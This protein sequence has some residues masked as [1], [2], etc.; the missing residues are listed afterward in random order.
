MKV[1]LLT[2]PMPASP[3]G[4]ALL[5]AL[6][7]VTAVEYTPQ[8][9]D[10][11]LAEVD[12]VLAWSFP[13]GVAGRLK[14]LRWVCAVSAGVDKLLVPELHPDVPVSRIVDPEQGQ[15]IAQ[16]VALMALRHARQ[17]PL[18]ERQARDHQWRRHPVAAVR[19]T[20]LVLGTGAMGSAVAD[21]LR[22]VGFDVRGWSRQQGGALDDALAAADIVVCALPLTPQTHGLLDARRLACMRK[23][24]YLINIA[25]GHHV[26]EADLVDAVRSG[27]LAGAALDVQQQ[28]PLPPDHPL[29]GVEGITITPHIAAQ[30]SV[31]TIATQFV[32]GLRCLLRG[33]PPPQQVDRQRGY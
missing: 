21:M 2:H 12:A 10:A 20:V 11:E 32:A 7:D 31:D 14:R 30:S 27:H 29:W 13:P 5:E 17:L 18:Y 25:R 28:E 15:G 22:S 9:G 3:Y 1:L 19:S 33:E 16:F 24:A 8:L 26:V 4:T 6:P 23:G